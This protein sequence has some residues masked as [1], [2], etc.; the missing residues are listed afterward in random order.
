MESVHEPDKRAWISNPVSVK[1]SYERWCE[2]LFENETENVTGSKMLQKLVLLLQLPDHVVKTLE[3][4]CGPKSLIC[5]GEVHAQSEKVTEIPEEVELM[6]LRIQKGELE[7]RRSDVNYKKYVYD[8]LKVQDYPERVCLGGVTNSQSKKTSSKVKLGILSDVLLTVQIFRPVQNVSNQK[9]RGV[10]SLLD[11][12]KSGFFYI[13]GVFYSDMRNT[14]NRDYSSQIRAW[15]KETVEKIGPFTSKKMED[16][17]FMDLDLRLGY[18]YVYVHQGFCEHLIVFSDLRLC[19]PDDSQDICDY[20][21]YL[22]TPRKQ[23]IICMVCHIKTSRWVTFGNKRVP[24][25]P[26]FFC[27]NCFFKY[28]YTADGKKIGDF[29]AHLYFDRTAIF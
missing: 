22:R 15:A 7:K 14:E 1:R 17:Q 28:N 8:R 2:S 12:Y 6:T 20:P 13:N 9:Y 27:E 26:F 5:E 18:P 16:C 3:T 24:E 23:R 21:M 4:E 25:D 10:E 11:L 29:Q 19:H